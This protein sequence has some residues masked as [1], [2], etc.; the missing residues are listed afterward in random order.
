MKIKQTFFKEFYTTYMDY[1]RVYYFNDVDT[2]DDKY[3]IQNSYQ[4]LKEK[5]RSLHAKMERFK[6]MEKGGINDN[7]WAS[8]IDLL[9]KLSKVRKGYL[10]NEIFEFLIK[11]GGFDYDY[12]QRLELQ[13]N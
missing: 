3:Q 8:L 5:F 10:M 12:N 13:I 1:W 2:Y 9:E 4:Y 11:M 6:Q 7:I